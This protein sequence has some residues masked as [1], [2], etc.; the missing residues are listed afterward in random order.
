M[1]YL[2]FRVVLLGRP[3][4][5]QTRS[6]AGKVRFGSQGLRVAFRGTSGTAIID[7]PRIWVIT[8]NIIE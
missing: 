5:G 7:V 2:A 1:L 6:T 3:V 8:Y 4:V